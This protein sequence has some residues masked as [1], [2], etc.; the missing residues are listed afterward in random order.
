MQFTRPLLQPVSMRIWAGNN[1]HIISYNATVTQRTKKLYVVWYFCKASH[2]LSQTLVV[3][4]SSL[5]P[6]PQLAH[7]IDGVLEISPKLVSVTDVYSLTLMKF[8]TFHILQTTFLQRFG[9]AAS[10]QRHSSVRS[11]QS[12]TPSHSLEIGRTTNGSLRHLKH[13]SSVK[14]ETWSYTL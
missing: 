3:F 12:N 14:S 8:E 13:L 1:Y 9:R 10:G 6:F 4:T 5:A 2:L 7:R 11:P